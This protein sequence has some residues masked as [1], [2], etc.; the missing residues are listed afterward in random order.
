LENSFPHSKSLLGQDKT[1]QKRQEI[2]VVSMLNT[3]KETKTRNE[4]FK[5]EYSFGMGQKFDPGVLP[6]SYPSCL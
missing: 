1:S 6:E 3:R 4:T 2:L 5:K